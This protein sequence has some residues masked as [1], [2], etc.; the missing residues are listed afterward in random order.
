[1]LPGHPGED[2]YVPMPD[3]TY[4]PRQI[5]NPSIRR[6]RSILLTT[7]LLD[8]L[9]S[10]FPVVALP[11]LR[12]RLHLTY[13]QAGFLFTAGALS[14]LLIEPAINL[15]ADRSSKRPLIA[16]GMI[17]MVLAFVVFGLAATYPLLILGFVVFYPATGA[18]VGLSQAALV[19]AQPAD[20]PQTMARWTLYSG[21]GDI[22]SP[23]AVSAL[24]ALGQGWPAICALGAAVWLAI[25]PPF[26]RQK[27]TV[28]Q[29]D[30]ST[31]T[32]EGKEEPDVSVRSALR[33]ALHDKL[34]LRWVA[35]GLFCNMLDE[36]FLAFAALY[37]RDRLH[38]SAEAVSLAVLAGTVGGLLS[39][40][41]LER[42][43]A[44]VDGPRLLPWLGLLTLAAVAIFLVAPGFA[45]A[46]LALFLVNVGAACWYP[47]AQAAAY[48]RLPG[49]SGTVQAVIAV[50][51]PFEIALPGIVGVLAANFGITAGV[52]FL[53]LAPL[54][55]LL[56]A[57]HSSGLTRISSARDHL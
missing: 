39:L 32:T 50:S 11:L 14:S 44:R 15:L 18:A 10:G 6:L 35:V 4:F 38:A 21:I 46:A 8:E 37:L 20:A 47:I 23:L 12:D 26:L 17:A 2:Y 36:I 43:L 25:L 42:L 1:M 33:A 22:L 9:T 31:S 16:A 54:G 48:A 34:L 49:R 5:T 19:D 24:L 52:A 40:V 30:P 45:L 55:V 41:I 27:L 28:T 29:P 53:G 7:A 13:A 56:L 3:S 57:P 51:A